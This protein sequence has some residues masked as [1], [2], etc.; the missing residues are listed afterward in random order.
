MQGA[1]LGCLLPVYLGILLEEPVSLGLGDWMS[2]QGEY[3]YCAQSGGP[4]L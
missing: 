4:E 2:P 3:P 1:E